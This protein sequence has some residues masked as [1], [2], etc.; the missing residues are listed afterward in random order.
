MSGLDIRSVMSVYNDVAAHNM[1]IYRIILC[2]LQLLVGASAEEDSKDQTSTLGMYTTSNI[3][4][5]TKNLHTP[6]Y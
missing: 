5:V 1:L 2:S 6:M 3:Y 4:T